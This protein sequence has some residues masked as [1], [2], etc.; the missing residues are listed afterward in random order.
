MITMTMH[1]LNILTTTIMSTITM[2]MHTTTNMV[3]VI[4]RKKCKL[5]ST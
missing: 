5:I 2:I 4:A 3:T 1:I